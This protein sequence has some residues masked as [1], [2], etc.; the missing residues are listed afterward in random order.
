MRLAAAMVSVLLVAGCASVSPST[1]PED[2]VLALKAGMPTEQIVALLGQPAAI[3]PTTTADG[4]PVEFWEY[5]IPIKR[6]V[7]MAAAGTIDVPAFDPLLGNE[8]AV[9]TVQELTYKPK[10]ETTVKI[11][12]LQIY[13][14]HLAGMR[15]GYEREDKFE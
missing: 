14:G 5:R 8:N 2:P 11:V 7:S 13:D 4:A 1:E 9:K 6:R 12:V 15:V 10:A 3:V